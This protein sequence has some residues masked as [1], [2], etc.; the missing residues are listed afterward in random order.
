[1]RGVIPYMSVSGRV[2][3]TFWGSRIYLFS[4]LRRDWLELLGKY[5]SRVLV[6][7]R[8]VDSV[9]SGNILRSHVWVESLGV[10]RDKAQNLVPVEDLDRAPVLV[11]SEIISFR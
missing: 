5:V 6:A 2:H 8:D 10:D 3:V 9:S 7:S 11:P 1:M 4:G